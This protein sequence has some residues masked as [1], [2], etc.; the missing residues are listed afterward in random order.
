MI[1]LPLV[2]VM[3]L[4]A[5]MAVSDQGADSV[6]RHL[7]LVPTIWVALARGALAGGLVGVLAGLL[8][9]PVVLPAVER[10]GITSQTLDGLLSLG[11]P[12]LAGL[13]VGHLADGA[14]APAA[15]GIS[16]RP[17]ISTMRK[18]F[19]SVRS[20]GTFPATGVMASI[21]SSGER[22]A[23]KSARAS[24]TPGSVSMM[25]RKGPR[26]VSRPDF[27]SDLPCSDGCPANAPPALAPWVK[28][29]AA[30]TAADDA[31]NWRRVIL[32]MR[33]VSC[34]ES[35]CAL[36]LESGLKS[37]LARLFCGPRRSRH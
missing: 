19:G 11:L 29:L 24:S 18:A 10:L 7:Y 21:F 14:R 26:P 6:L 36:L 5:V 2:L 25:T 31:T 12:A 33:K 37:C 1:A 32:G 22:M 8:H 30:K 3:G 4:A 28:P 15:T 34:F 35:T 27:P 20:S 9:A 13:L 16:V 23:S 17:A